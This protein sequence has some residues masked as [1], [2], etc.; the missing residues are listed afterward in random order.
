MSKTST[1]GVA[2]LLAATWNTDLMYEF[3]A[4]LRQEA[5]MYNITGWYSPA[6][7][8]HRSLFSGRVFDYYSED[9]LLSGMMAAAA[10]AGCMDNGMAVYS[11][12]IFLK[13]ALTSFCL[14][15]IIHPSIV[16]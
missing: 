11:V 15:C 5:L 4:A 13:K 6:I 8:L 7:N 1:F 3:G 2:L 12:L 9:P 16:P 10:I 14:Y